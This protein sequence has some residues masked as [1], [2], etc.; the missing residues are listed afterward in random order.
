MQCENNN[1]KLLVNTICEYMRE[2]YKLEFEEGQ[3]CTIDEACRLAVW[4]EREDFVEVLVR[5][6]A[7]VEVLEKAREDVKH[8]NGWKVMGD[9]GM[10]RLIK[11]Q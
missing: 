3:K 8:W 10:W 7:K 4:Q 6:G 2:L 1:E 5:N 9:D 11:S